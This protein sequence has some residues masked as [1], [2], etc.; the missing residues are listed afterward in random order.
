MQT[1]WAY[2]KICAWSGTISPT[3]PPSCSWDFCASRYRIVRPCLLRCSLCGFPILTLCAAYFLQVVPAGKW[4]GAN[5]VLWGVATACGGA[6]HDYRSLLVSRIFLGVF[7]ATIGPS[8]L[9][10]SSQ[11]YTKSEQ[12]PRFSLW[13]LGLGLGQII[14]GAVS[15]GFQHVA[16]GS[17]YLAGWRIMFITLGCATVIVGLLTLLLLPD[18]P[19]HARWLTDGEKVALLKHVSINQT[20]IQNRR[21]RIREIFEALA[22]PQIYLLIVAVVSVSYSQRD[23]CLIWDS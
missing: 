11:Y 15:Y 2:Q 8:L 14:G 21:F 13:Y 18:T 20:G 6:A 5:V 9:L 22:D 19:M 23:P 3:L 16:P 1:S 17:A 10:I 7:E 4:L 12:A